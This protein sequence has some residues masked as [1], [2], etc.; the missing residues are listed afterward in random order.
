[1]HFFSVEL[2]TISR[3]KRNTRI[4]NARHQRLGSSIMKRHA[5]LDEARV[6][7]QEVKRKLARA[8]ELIRR[9]KCIHADLVKILPSGPRDNGEAAFV[10]A[11]CGRSL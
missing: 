5:D 10:C 11:K 7:L 1:M 8:A 9:E 6:L 2:S 4:E 3:A